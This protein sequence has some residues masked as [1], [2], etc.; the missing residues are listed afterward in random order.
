MKPKAVSKSVGLGLYV[1]EREGFQINKPIAQGSLISII[2][3]FL[4]K[5]AKRASTMTK[6]NPLVTNLVMELRGC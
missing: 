6:Y 2:L 4:V 1:A 5:P 3:L